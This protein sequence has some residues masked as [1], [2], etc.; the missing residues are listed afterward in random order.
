ME[1]T[2]LPTL[3][4]ILNSI[5]TILL[6][7]GFWAIKRRDAALHKRFMLAAF[8]VSTLFLISYLIYH[9]NVGSVPFQG[10]GL[11]RVVYFVVLVPHIILAMVQVPLILIALYRAFK[12]QIEAHRKIVKW[13]YPIWL[14]VSVTGVVVY[15]ML[16]QMNFD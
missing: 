9:F 1:L 5:S 11:V 13:A 10:T 4:A 15:I 3:N 12:N 7:L 16:Y 8:G 14:Y 6:L 2:N